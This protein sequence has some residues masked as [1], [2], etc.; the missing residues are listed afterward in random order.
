[1]SARIVAV[2]ATFRRPHELERL[3]ASLQGLEL[4]VV[5]DNS[6]DE[7]IRA[8]AANAPLPVH[9]LAPGE[10]LGC[11][12]GLRLAE[13]TVLELTGGA[14]THWLILDDDAVL[15]PD[16]LPSLLD[17]LAREDADVAYPLAV[18]PDGLAGWMPGLKDRAQHRLDRERLSPAE[19]R[20]RI[21][22]EVAEFSWAQGI[23]L[24]ARAE[25]VAAAG[26]HR[27]DFWIRGEDLDFSLRLTARGRGIFCPGVEVQHLP[28][29]NSAPA[30]QRAEYLRH[31]AMIQNIAYLGWTQVHGAPIRWSIAGA[32]RR[33]L[34]L[35]GLRA[36]PD[37]ARAI[38]RGLCG[39]AAGQGR[40]KTFFQ[41]FHE[42]VLR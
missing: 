39:E 7:A 31:A 40:G 18:G 26:L 10:N 36:V 34:Q 20:R 33:F 28:P 35:W 4:A 29:D 42:L 21:G 3:L 12:G 23:C 25:A 37:L 30:D 14:F 13:E 17:L 22:V 2:I 9:Y 15:G 38:F 11:G 41:R 24:L 27:G 19:Y 5:C 8:V 1:M 32:S 6:G 16:T